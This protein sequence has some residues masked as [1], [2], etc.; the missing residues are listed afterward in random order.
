M[1]FSKGHTWIEGDSWSPPS[2]LW[3][4]GAEPQ[5]LLSSQVHD[6]CLLNTW[7][8]ERLRCCSHWVLCGALNDTTTENEVSHTSLQLHSIICS[9]THSWNTVYEHFVMCWALMSSHHYCLLETYSPVE[10][11][12][13]K[14]VHAEH[15]VHVCHPSIH[16]A[17]AGESQVW[18]RPGLFN[19]F[20]ASLGYRMR[21][22]LPSRDVVGELTEH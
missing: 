17:E 3:L 8:K 7:S 21:P 20:Q 19:M 11:Q 10:G 9:L 18:G 22:Y 12:A 16:G 5:Y 1:R 13:G 15:I 2:S 6:G 14:Q 4:S